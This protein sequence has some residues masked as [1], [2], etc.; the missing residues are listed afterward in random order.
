M[1]VTCPTCGA[2]AEV[3]HEHD[4]EEG[5]EERAVP[6]IVTDLSCGHEAVT[7]TTWAAQEARLLDRYAGSEP[8]S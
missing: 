1:T 7:R 8:C 2:D 4:E 3:L 6:V 5:W